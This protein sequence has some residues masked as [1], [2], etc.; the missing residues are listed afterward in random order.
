MSELWKTQALVLHSIAWKDSSKIVDLFTREHGYQKVIVRGVLRP[1]SPL[2]GSLETLNRVEVIISHKETRGL[3][4]LTEAYLL[5]PFLKLKEDLN[6]LAVG[7]AM[8]E[9]IRK[10]FAVHEPAP[11]FYDETIRLLEAISESR[12]SNIWPFL[13]YFLFKISAALGIGWTFDRCIRCQ[14]PLVLEPGARMDI[15]GGGLICN[16]CR[17]PAAES[18]NNLNK[19]QIELLNT[20]CYKSLE[21]VIEKLAA[22]AALKELNLTRICLSHINY[23]TESRLELKSLNWYRV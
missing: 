11:L 5:T 14:R 12:D 3:Q 22:L 18:K 2:R 23:H 9:L 16:R 19:E 6:K 20:L 13:W 21:T 4:L 8:G 10:L 7:F 17:R 1:K 15:R